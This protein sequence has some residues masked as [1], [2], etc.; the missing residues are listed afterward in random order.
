MFC[1]Y[2]GRGLPEHVKFCPYCGNST[3][4]E[5]VEKCCPACGWSTTEDMV[6]CVE[7]GTTL[8]EKVA[9]KKLEETVD[10][11]ADITPV[12]TEG[13]LRECRL[14]S[15]Y[16]GA[17]KVGIAKATGTIRLY[18]DRLEI[19]NKLGNA[20]GSV[21]GLVG[22]AAAR[23]KARKEPNTILLLKNL[24]KIEIGKY[25]G[26]FNTLYLESSDHSPLTLVPPV[27]ASTEPELLKMKISL[28]LNG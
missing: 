23:K 27:P 3:S 13:L 5:K 6:Y 12:G 18:S 4:R 22:V 14:W 11:T 8:Q 21:F 26:A 28:L 19:E 16:E 10:F 25:C 20:L 7:C 24:T 1:S 2:C 15:V 9:E 17:P